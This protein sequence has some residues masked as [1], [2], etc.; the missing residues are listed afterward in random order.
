VRELSL[1]VLD[2]VE[3]SL[4]A[5]ATRLE[6]EII[7]DAASNLL[8]ISLSD[9]GRGMDQ[10]TLKRVA[11][12]FF[13]TRTTRQV[14]LGIPLLRAAALRCNGDLAITSQPGLGTCVLA[15]FQRD[16]IDRAPLGDM[17]GTLLSVILSQKRCDLHYRHQVDERVFEFDTEEIRE[18][19]GGLPLAHPR[20]RVW[21]EDF[22]AE[23]YAR[24]YAE[25]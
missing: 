10:E 25:H 12:P 18:A 7:E 9:N 16:H 14:G 24:L 3:N 6:L 5:G 15:E 23:G 22:L 2:L 19:L 17:R 11:D 1:H 20:V 8:T 4:A 13:T 21:L